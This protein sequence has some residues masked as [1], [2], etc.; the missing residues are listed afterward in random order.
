MRGTCKEDD[1]G[2]IIQAIHWELHKLGA[3]AWFEW[4]DTDANCS[5][6][7]SRDGLNDEWTLAQPWDISWAMPPPWENILDTRQLVLE[8]LGL[9]L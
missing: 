9:V 4:V 6:G 7:L 3:R 8:T 2:S 5:D 1:V